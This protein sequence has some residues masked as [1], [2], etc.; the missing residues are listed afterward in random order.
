[1][2]ISYGLVDGSD[3]FM[4]E[5]NGEYDYLV[6]NIII[7]MLCIIDSLVSL[8]GLLLTDRCIVLLPFVITYL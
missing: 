8:F 3:I 1:M 5:W 6:Y 2:S 4:G 7:T